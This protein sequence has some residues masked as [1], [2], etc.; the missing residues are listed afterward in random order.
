MR[1][2][3]KYRRFGLALALADTLAIIV[4]WYLA[5]EVRVWMTHLYGY[6]VNDPGNY[7]LALPFIVLIWLSVNLNNGL[8]AHRQKT[9]QLN[10]LI[11]IFRTCFWG[12]I[13]TMAM[14]YFFK[15][16]DLGR[17]VVGSMP[18]LL[19]LWLFASRS[20]LRMIKQSHF[21]RGMGLTRAAIV[22]AGQTG[23]EVMGRLLEHPEVGFDLVGF[24]DDDP[25][26]QGRE[27]DGRPVLGSSRSLPELIGRL[28]IEE[29]FIAIPSLP[30]SDALSLIVKAEG[31][32]ATFKLVSN[33]LQVITHE[34]KVD[35]I[36]DIPVIP[37]PDGHLE[38]HQAT[39]KRLFDITGALV[40]LV[41]LSPLWLWIA[42]R[43]RRSS[44]GPAIFSH[45]RVGKDGR[46][47]RLHKFRTMRA[48]ADPQAKAPDTGDDPRI[49]SSLAWLRRTSLDELPQLL[50]V[51]RGEMSL[52]G[53]RPEMPFIVNRY[54]EWQRRRLFVKP[55]LTGLWQVIGRKNL[56]L[57][58]NLEY[59]F[60]Y[61][62]NQSFWLDLSILLRTIP[63][64][65]L[66]RGAF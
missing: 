39:L 34:I 19:F 1:P 55:G 15:G 49:I 44:P 52:V 13:C 33:M 29:V 24:I 21:R 7:R 23:R 12:L 58:L 50:N 42:W 48:D 6:P 41:A 37:I 8:Y 27:I 47:F 53:P 60:Y 2:F 40:L 14:A 28:G 26:K 46:P 61:I 22:G 54:E 31:K 11:N 35:E 9:S 63:A 5:Y 64:V 4:C 18:F 20:A 43:I 36:G 10:N 38:W 3:W 32:G 56:P 66:G 62:K 57:S 30:L 25:S 17:S 16:L 65:V 59:D 51:L 45:V